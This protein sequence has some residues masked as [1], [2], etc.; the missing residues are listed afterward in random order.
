M[1]RQ[2]KRIPKKINYRDQADMPFR[3]KSLKNLKGEKWKAIPG[4]EDLYKISNHGR[5]KSLEREIQQKNGVTKRLKEQIKLAGVSPTSNYFKGDHTYQ[6]AAHFVANGKV[7]NYSVARLVYQLFVK[8][9]SPDDDT[10]INIIQK[11]GNGLNCHYENL[12]AV[13]LTDRGK[14]IFADGRNQ[15]SF[16]QLDKETRK[17]TAEK[18]RKKYSQ[19]VTQYDLKGR[20]IRSFN[21]MTEA[22]KKTGILFESIRAASKGLNHKAGNYIWKPGKAKSNIVSAGILHLSAQNI[23]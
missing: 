17:K 4:F 11:D 7:Y 19:P 12:V 23:D 16:S 15:S 5:I 22:S 13:S 10:T 3:N 8:P 20:P 21:S 2:K 6:L 14:R 9:L 1:M 18:L